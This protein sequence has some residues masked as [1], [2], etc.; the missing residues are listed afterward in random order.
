MWW[1]LFKCTASRSLQPSLS[2]GHRFTSEPVVRCQPCQCLL[3]RYLGSLK[4]HETWDLRLAWLELRRRARHVHLR[5]LG[6]VRLQTRLCWEAK[7]SRVYLCN[8]TAVPATIMST[9]GGPFETWIGSVFAVSRLHKNRA[10]LCWN[11]LFSVFD[12]LTLTG[13]TTFMVDQW[14]GWIM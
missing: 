8:L 5:P 9:A 1:L 11:E 13:T 10:R 7:I 14:Q 6:G 4:S 12:G 2:R 3:P